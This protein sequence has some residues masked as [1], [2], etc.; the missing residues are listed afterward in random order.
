[1]KLVVRARTLTKRV[2][3]TATA[4]VLA[5]SGAVS[6]VPYFVSTQVNAVEGNPACVQ[7]GDCYATIQSAVD[8]AKANDTINIA[9]GTYNESV[10]IDKALTIKGA[11]HEKDA[12]TRTIDSTSETIVNGGDKTVFTIGA[13]NVTLDG[14]QIEQV[15]AVSE[16]IST[17]TNYNNITIV[18]NIVTRTGPSGS[19]ARLYGGY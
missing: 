2:T 11:Q 4:F 12:R 14:L 9:T 5:L 16:A 7:G 8:A 13:S 19:A 1:M 15:K 3:L 18:N 10:T 6:A 17:P